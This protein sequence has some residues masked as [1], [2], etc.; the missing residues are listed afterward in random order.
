MRLGI[1]TSEHT[2]AT[3]NHYA[4]RYMIVSTLM[5]ICFFFSVFFVFSVVQLAKL[6]EITRKNQA[7]FPGCSPSMG[8]SLSVDSSQQ[9]LGSSQ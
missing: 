5:T 9:V 3:E 2:E 4:V 6:S 7:K 1:S 8:S